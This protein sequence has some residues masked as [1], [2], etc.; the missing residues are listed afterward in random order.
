MIIYD[1]VYY[2]SR[3]SDCVENSRGRP[4][5]IPCCL[6]N[7]DAT[8]YNHLGA[9]SNDTSA[10][11]ISQAHPADLLNIPKYINILRNNHRMII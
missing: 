8:G 3:W 9:E 6:K 5:L 4:C 2:L 7:F 1:K 10:C 11:E